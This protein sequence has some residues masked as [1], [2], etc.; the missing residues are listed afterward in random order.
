MKTATRKCLFDALHELDKGVIPFTMRASLTI[1][2][3]FEKSISC[4]G[5]TEEDAQHG[6]Y[7]E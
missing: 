2:I 4:K 7:N 3:T 5:L 6:Q 1:C